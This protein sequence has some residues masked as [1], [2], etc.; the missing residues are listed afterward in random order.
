[1]DDE[2]NA[3]RTMHS[4]LK[5]YA[6]NVEV[7]AE[8]SSVATA[9]QAIKEHLPDLVFL[10]I[11]MQDGTGFEVLQNLPQIDFNVV[12]VTAYEQYALQSFR[13]AA[14]DYLL[15]PVRIQE[16]QEAIARVAERGKSTITT[17]KDFKAIKQ[18]I[19]ASGTEGPMVL[20]TEVDGFTIVRYNEILYLEAAKNYTVF[21]FEGRKVIASRSMGEYEELLAEFGF[22]RI[23]K[24]YIVNLFKV[25]RYVKGRGGEVELCDGTA[26]PIARERKQVFLEHFEARFGLI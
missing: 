8:A 20:I 25:E 2:A 14:I 22:M 5:N 23:H 18:K 19:D 15:K 24:S 6:P 26:I 16:L 17:G 10:D 3:R 21:V 1:M 9:L 4:L 7:V 12:F 13:F 11:E